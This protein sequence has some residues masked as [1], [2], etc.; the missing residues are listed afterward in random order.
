LGTSRSGDAEGENTMARKARTGIKIK[1]L[2]RDVKVSEEEMKH[3]LGGTLAAETTYPLW[4][5]ISAVLGR[6]N[7]PPPPPSNRSLRERL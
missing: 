1:D 5:N 7:P 6:G 4:G 2:P 3:V